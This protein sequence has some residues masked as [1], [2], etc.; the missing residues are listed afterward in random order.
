MSD[1][2]L[3]IKGSIHNL[4]V[5]SRALALRVQQDRTSDHSHS[6]TYMLRICRPMV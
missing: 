2:R 6:G 3:V 1:N 4:S 5:G